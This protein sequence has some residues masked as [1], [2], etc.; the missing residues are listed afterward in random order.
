LRDLI[1]GMM[2]DALRSVAAR[3]TMDELHE[4]RAH[5]VAEVIAKSKKERAAIDADSEVSV[6]RASMEA[7]R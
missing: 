3:M 4:N 5:F 1:D 6:R 7:S 2:V